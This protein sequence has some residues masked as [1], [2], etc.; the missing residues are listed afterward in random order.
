MGLQLAREEEPPATIRMMASSEGQQSGT[1]WKYLPLHRAAI[2][3][4][5][6]SARKIFQEDRNAP[7]ALVNQ[8]KETALHV[9]V[10]TG[11]A[12]HFVKELV[13]FMP[14]DAL[15]IKNN[16][17]LTAP[18]QA[19]IVGYTEAATILLENDPGLL[20]IRENDGGLPATIAAVCAQRDTLIH[21]ISATASNKYLN[22]DPFP[23]QKDVFF[24]IYTLQCEY[25]DVALDL[26][27]QYPHL[28]TFKIDGDYM[29]L[30]TMAQKPG[31]FR[32]GSRLS[33]L[34]NLIYNAVPLRLESDPN[35]VEGDAE[36]PAL[37]LPHTDGWSSRLVSGHLSLSLSHTKT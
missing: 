32:R 29:P 4:D 28:A 24:L 1:Y 19:A 25:F 23:E 8:F 27:K 3:G 2:K 35:K 30:N 16:L 9:V 15:S 12:I 11:K 10:K 7:T 13:K 33:W 18:H 36:N 31:V 22:P 26:I 14:K 34:E 21:L 20:Y 5:W 17:G 37:V 6:E